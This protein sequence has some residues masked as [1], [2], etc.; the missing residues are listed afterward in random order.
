M[1]GPSPPPPGRRFPPVRSRTG[2]CSSVCG[3]SS[4]SK[5]SKKD[6]VFPLA[7]DVHGAGICDRTTRV[8]A[9]F[10]ACAL[11]PARVPHASPTLFP[12]G[13]VCDRFRIDGVLGI[14]GTGTVFRGLDLETKRPVAV[15]DIPHEATL[16]QRARLVHP[17]KQS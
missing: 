11:M 13:V 8:S 17:T 9:D 10:E 15:K 2:L 12:E 4:N 3:A 6:S 1:L 5:S 14:G 16:R 7:N